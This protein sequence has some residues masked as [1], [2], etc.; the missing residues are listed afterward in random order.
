MRLI[1]LITALL[2]TAPAFADE[3]EAF[4]WMR[5]CWRTEAPREAESGATYTEVWIAPPGPA[6]FGYAYNEGEGAFRGWEQMRIERADGGAYFVAMPNGDAPVRFR[7]DGLARAG[8]H[9]SHVATFENPQHDYP[10]RVRYERLGNNLTATIS[11]IDGGNPMM[12][13]YRRIRCP[14][15]LR[16]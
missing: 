9:G 14:A 3:L 11:T 12:F 8:D 2:C 16:P 1:I 6:M 7:W 4:T 13:A 10:Q 15:N 5:G